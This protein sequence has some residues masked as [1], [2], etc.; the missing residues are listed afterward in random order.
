MK[1]IC[2]APD[3]ENFNIYGKSIGMEGERALYYSKS[4]HRQRIYRSSYP[5]PCEKDFKLFIYKDKSKA[6]NLCDLV[7]K[8]Y[9]DNFV[10]TEVEY[11]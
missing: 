2:V 7:N 5:T 8:V 1:Y 6:Q 4:L 3:K 11:D 10:V 9:K